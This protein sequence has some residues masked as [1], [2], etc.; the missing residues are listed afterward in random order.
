M[1]A[2]KTVLSKDYFSNA[3]RMTLAQFEAFLKNVVMN[4]EP[5]KLAPIIIW[6]APGVAKS[7]II[8][9]VVGVSERGLKTVILSQIGPLD[10]NGLPHIEKNDDGKDTT[11][12]SATDTFG[13]GKKH[14]FLDE[15]NNAAP[16]T[17]AA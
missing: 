7:A 14:L 8:E 15:L 9:Q 12:F 3:T 2:S 17:L 16:S 13:R 11:K 4:T 6:G 1:A 5:R 10:S